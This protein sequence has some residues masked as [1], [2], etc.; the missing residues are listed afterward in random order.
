MFIANLCT[1][2]EGKAPTNSNEEVIA[3]IKKTNRI[4]L[5]AF[6]LEPKEIRSI[7]DLCLPGLRPTEYICELIGQKP[8][9][10]CLKRIKQ[11]LCNFFESNRLVTAISNLKGFFRLDDFQLNLHQK[12]TQS[13]TNSLIVFELLIDSFSTLVL[14]HLQTSNC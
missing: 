7:S 9:K 2:V 4:F 6:S 1:V 13:L 11:K 8:C 3:F 14:H 10:D 12:L 5:R